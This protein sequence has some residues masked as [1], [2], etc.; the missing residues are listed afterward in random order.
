MP[1]AR[2]SRRPTRRGFLALTVAACST[3]CARQARQAE[4]D[5]AR[6][7]PEGESPHRLLTV[8]LVRH[9]EKATDDPDD[10]SL[11][12]AG[13]E[14]ALAL[15]RLLRGAGVSHLFASEYR[16]AAATVEPLARMTGVEITRLPARD[17]AGL[18]GR[19][20]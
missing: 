17:V 8:V 4:P 13:R 15:A 19:L 14:R 2:L 16:R 20:S 9:A 10:P 18:V 11:S 5:P 6:R 3:S 7:I 1:E 12:D